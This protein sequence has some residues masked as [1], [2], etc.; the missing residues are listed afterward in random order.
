MDMV[1]VKVI[2]TRAVAGVA[3]GGTVE[4]DP[5]RVNIAALVDAGHVEPAGSAPARKARA[6]ESGGSGG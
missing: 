1:R 4:L 5:E 6:D 2:G 3:P